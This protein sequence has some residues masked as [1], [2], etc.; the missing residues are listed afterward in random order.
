MKKLL[1]S[2]CATALTASVAVTERVPAQRGADLMSRRLQVVHS[3]V[4]QIRDRS[5]MSGR[6]S[7]RKCSS[8][9][10]RISAATGT[11]TAIGTATGTT[12][13]LVQRPSRLSLYAATGAIATTTAS[14]SRLAAF[15]AGAIIGGAIANSNTGYYRGGGGSAHVEWCYDRY[16]SYRAYDNTFQPYNG[17]RQQCYSPYADRTESGFKTPRRRRGLFVLHVRV[18]RVVR[19]APRRASPS[20]FGCA[21]SSSISGLKRRSSAQLLANSLAFGQTPALEPASQAAPS[22]VVSSIVGPVDRRVEDV[23]EPLHRPVGRHHAA[24]DAQHGLGRRALPVLLHGVEQ[25]ARLVGDGFQRRAGEFGRPGIAR[26]AEDRAARL[27]I[28]MRRA[29]TDEGR[30]EIDVLRRRRPW[31]PARRC[32]RPCRSFSA[33]RAAT[34]RPRRR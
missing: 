29:E 6:R 28:P 26:Q 13:R 14:G 34:A 5:P 10:T 19:R 1:S 4:M 11:A 24:V 21:S 27:G 9:T 17:P 23:G 20:A 31:P 30:H 8:A 7:D 3:D 25:V 18:G 15:V 16:R 32:A 12:I 2:L 22:A 33:R